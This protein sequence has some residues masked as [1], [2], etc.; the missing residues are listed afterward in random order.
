MN[1]GGPAVLVAELANDLVHRGFSHMLITGA[2]EANEKDFL[3]ENYVAGK[4]VYVKRLAR[5][6]IFINEIFAIREIV[7]ILRRE[8]PDVVHTHMSKA[9]VLGRLAA[10]IAA[11]KAVVIH[12][13]HGHLLYGY[14]GSFKT[15]LVIRV[16]R[17]L[18]HFSDYLIGITKAV[19][20]DLQ[21]AK[22]GRRGQ[23]RIIRLGVRIEPQHNKDQARRALG[24]DENTFCMMWL[25]RFAE[26]KNPKFALEI[27][28]QLQGKHS[29]RL[30]MGGGGDLL[31]D[32]KQFAQEHK[33]NVTFLGWIDNI[34]SYL[35][36]ADL[37]ILT[38]KNEGMGMVVLEAASQGVPT[39]STDV[40][41]VSEFITDHETGFFAESDAKT[42]AQKV[43]WI[44]A[45]SSDRIK[46]GNNARDLLVDQFS[47][48]EFTSNHANLYLESVEKKRSVLKNGL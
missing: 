43:S 46:V 11:P 12:T 40:G 8:K 32:C 36:A 7:N 3:Q 18:A 45:H 33:L 16:E 29:L 38:S 41:G 20:A 31:S 25:G 4:V 1:I 21:R 9:G 24:I 23:W 5:S 17:L 34:Y 42:F 35:S 30:I 27:F 37:L 14:F 10:R 22:V 39:I 15:H 19:G 47:I 48:E 44:A 13:Y 6:I 2:C 28:A 26:I